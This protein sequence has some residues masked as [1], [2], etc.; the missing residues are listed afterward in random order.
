MFE[1]VSHTRMGCNDGHQSVSI[2]RIVIVKPI[3]IYPNNKISRF[4]EAG[5]ICFNYLRI[6]FL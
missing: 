3:R 5:F 4:V 2:E 6:N 1:T